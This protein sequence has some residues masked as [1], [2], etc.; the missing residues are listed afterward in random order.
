MAKVVCV[1]YDD[2]IGGHPKSY[3][4]E[5]A[6]RNLLLGRPWLQVMDAPSA[7]PH[8]VSRCS[9]WLGIATGILV[10]SQVVSREPP[11]CCTVLVGMEV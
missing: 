6:D 9:L 10:G 8:R 1:L 7:G 2:P 4:R 5:L 11:V 3:A